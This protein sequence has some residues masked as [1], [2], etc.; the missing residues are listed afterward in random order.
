MERLLER[1]DALAELGDVARQVA[2]GGGGRLV[3]VRGEAGV[4]KTAVLAHFAAGLDSSM[5]VLRGWCD[6]LAAPR[7]LGP[8][9]DAL[10]GVGTAAAGALDSAIQSADTGVLYRRLLSLLGDGQHWVWVIEDAHWADGATLDLLRFLGRRVDSLPL[11]LVVSYRDDELDR[12]HPLSVVLGDV[13]TCAAVRRIRLEPLSRH[14]VAQL[15]AGSGVNA[16]R[17]HELT[18]GNPFFVTEVLAA[19]PAALSRQ[20]L[21]RSIAEAVRG[22]LARLSPAAGETAAA[23]AICGP[24]VPVALVEKMCPAASLGLAEC[25]DAGVLVE[26]HDVID[27]RHELARRATADQIANYQRRALHRRALAVLAEPPIEPDALAALVFHAEQAGDADAVIRYGPAAA[28]RASVLGANR[29]AA[30][31]YELTLRHA[32]SVPVEQ[33]VR[34][35]EQHALTCYLCGLAGA[36]VSSWRE[37]IRWRLALGDSLGQSENLRWLSHELWGMGHV[38]EAF[39]AARTALQL[40]Q[41]SG[42]SSQLG[43]ALV[44]LGE[45]GSWGF[46]P[47]AADYAARA[48]A[49]G[50]GIDDNALV[51]RASAA[52]ATAQILTTNT[53]WEQLE[54]A[55]RDAMAAETRG[56]HA[57]LLATLVC[58]LAALHYDLDRA[59]RYIGESVVYCRDHN[60]FTFE[61]LVVGVDAIVRL[62]RGN[63][64]H[65][66]TAAE[67]LF[68]RPGLAAVNRILPQLILALI[69]AR[70]GQRSAVTLLDDIVGGAETDH[71][72]LFS[73]WAARAE[74]AWLAGDD[75]TCRR[76][77]RAGLAATGSRADPWLVGALHRWLYLAGGGSAPSSGDPHTPFELELRGDWQAA[78]E[79]WLR[80]GC[81]YDAAIAQLGGDTAAV[82]SAQDT[83]RQLG[84]VAAAR[85]AQQRLAA[86]RGRTHRGPYR[87]TRAD[88]DGLT[89]R[90]REV[91]DLLSAG[92]DAAEIA[93]ILHISTKTANNHVQAILA[94]LGV[95]NR[96]QAVAHVLHRRTTTP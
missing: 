29:Q 48:I 30:E 90:Q 54:A 5:R 1:R 53:G 55:W 87:Q 10:P 31:L 61:A 72:R 25:L 47:A 9:I 56:E 39:D 8:L 69:D 77:A 42:P 91:L 75:G 35:I 33:K 15:T 14:A 49:V 62:H 50:T 68:T 32:D 92:H 12:Q 84:A 64:D 89:R 16:E 73:V 67:D 3:L 38:R 18:G 93:I 94:K 86:L 41:D 40:V 57:G 70:R 63:W 96:A 44:N 88:P 66:R 60:V 45:L 76:E 2:R 21:P 4:G 6:P 43:W 19:G 36:A 79:E 52:A 24:R 28:E 46:D 78:V 23:V 80:R 81:R 34:W 17:L 71:L 26:L 13:A 7:P 59:E 22:R 27:F 65:A 95:T 74:A 37:A 51:I 82:Q 85:R 11:L 58:W 20:G 83:F